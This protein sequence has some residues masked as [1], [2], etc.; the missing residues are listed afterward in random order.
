MQQQARTRRSR[1]SDGGGA[2]RTSLDSLAYSSEGSPPVRR[3]NHAGAGGSNLFPHQSRPPSGISVPASV[4]AWLNDDTDNEDADSSSS[5]EDVEQTPERTRGDGALTVSSAHTARNASWGQVGP[6]TG[7]ATTDPLPLLRGRGATGAAPG[8]PTVAAVAATAAAAAAAATV[9]RET[10]VTP[11]VGDLESS[12]IT[13]ARV[14]PP[15]S[16]SVPA[17]IAGDAVVPVAQEQQK[18]HLMRMPEGGGTASRSLTTIKSVTSSTMNSMPEQHSVA[19]NLKVD[20]SFT[21]RCGGD[22]VDRA[23]GAVVASPAIAQHEPDVAAE[24]SRSENPVICSKEQDAILLMAVKPT[25]AA[26]EEMNNWLSES[27]GEG[28]E[29]E[30]HKATTGTN[31]KTRPATEEVVGAMHVASKQQQPSPEKEK[32]TKVSTDRKEG[33]KHGL[34]MLKPSASATDE[35][36]SWLTDSDEENIKPDH[37]V[38]VQSANAGPGKAVTIATEK[39]TASESVEA[40]RISSVAKQQQ[41]QQPHHH[42]RQC[43]ARSGEE[44]E[45]GKLVASSSQSR[46]A[47]DEMKRWL[48]WSDDEAAATVT[49]AGA[50]VDDNDGH[51][52]SEDN[53]TDKPAAA[54]T[55]TVSGKAKRGSKEGGLEGAKARVLLQTPPPQSHCLLAKGDSQG[56][57]GDT[58]LHP[59][60]AGVAGSSPMGAKVAR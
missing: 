36:M 31:N 24:P 8:R 50:A 40:T 9:M 33:G 14:P 52:P 39:T 25:V 7:P 32:G 30:M 51:I 12:D 45:G 48:S 37:G 46:L 1:H 55:A 23:A 42:H 38:T 13:F 47:M 56:K 44:P 21:T 58:S 54:A 16:S 26:M 22:A 2:G 60:G 20:D 5:G 4:R 18:Q 28:E 59:P 29:I 17:A 11:A 15:V 3:S 35:M 41:Q 49:T 10:G 6:S 53:V 27:D 57:Q 34:A 43:P 19:S